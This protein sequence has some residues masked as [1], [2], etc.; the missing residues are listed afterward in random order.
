[1]VERC[2]GVVAISGM[3][4]VVLWGA[5]REGLQVEVIF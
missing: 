4:C 5:G 3:L 2:V 1:M